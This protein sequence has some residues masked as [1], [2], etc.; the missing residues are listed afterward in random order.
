MVDVDAS[1]HIATVE[2]AHAIGY[3]TVGLLPYHAVDVDILTTT[4]DDPVAVSGNGPLPQQTA[5]VRLGDYTVLP[6][7]Y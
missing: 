4:D 1:R 3:G 2:D 5:T 7:D 6:G